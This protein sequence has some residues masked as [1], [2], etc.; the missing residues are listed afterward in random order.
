MLSLS[1][2]LRTLKVFVLMLSLSLLLHTLKSFFVDVIAVV[3]TAYSKVFFLLMLSLSLLLHALNSLFFCILFCCL[4]FSDIFMAKICINL[5]NLAIRFAT[6]RES[7]QKTCET[8]LSSYIQAQV[9][10]FK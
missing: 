2:L 7:L 4:T 9:I 1:F 10:F 5:L 6:K 8:V 3:V